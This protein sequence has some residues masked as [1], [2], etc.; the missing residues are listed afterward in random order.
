MNNYNF[1]IWL[2][3]AQFILQDWDRDGFYDCA[4][5]N[6]DSLLSEHAARYPYT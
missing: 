2:I 4:V 6:I 5:R 3:E 1:I